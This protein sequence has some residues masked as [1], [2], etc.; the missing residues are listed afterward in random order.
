MWWLSRSSIASRDRRALSRC[1]SSHDLCVDTSHCVCV[2]LCVCVCVYTCVRAR[3]SVLAS[4]YT[5]QYTQQTIKHKPLC[6]NLLDV[7]PDSALLPVHIYGRP[8]Q[9]DQHHVMGAYVFLS[10]FSITLSLALRLLK[11]LKVMHALR[12]FLSHVPRRFTTWL[13]CFRRH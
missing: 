5:H 11:I 1:F 12:P 4:T 7:S 8:K 10:P 6:L 13:R 9:D 3:M 2:C